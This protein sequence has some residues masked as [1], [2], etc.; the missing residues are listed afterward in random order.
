MGVVMEIAT[1]LTN[2]SYLTTR[3]PSNCSSTENARGLCYI[4]AILRHFKTMLST[5]DATL[6]VLHAV[7]PQVGP[8]QRG[9]R[10]PPPLHPLQ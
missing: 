8:L 3:Q 9:S 10:H 6:Q 2:I 4:P 7:K 1:I 5:I